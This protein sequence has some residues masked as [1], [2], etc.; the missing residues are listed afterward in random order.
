MPKWC[1][2]SAP[3]PFKAN[4]RPK[5][6]S[7]RPGVTV[8]H[9]AAELRL[10]GGRSVGRAIAIGWPRRPAFRAP[11]GGGP[12]VVAARG[13]EAGLPVSSPPAP[14]PVPEECNGRDGRQERR[15]PIR[16]QYPGPA[17]ARINV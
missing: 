15:Q 1:C 17:H 2:G 10:R 14:P 12:E 9:F 3:H 4:G 16:G 7:T 5:V 8:P 13:T 11:V 6:T